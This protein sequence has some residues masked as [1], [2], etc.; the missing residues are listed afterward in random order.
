MKTNK[1]KTETMMFPSLLMALIPTIA[2][3]VHVIAIVTSK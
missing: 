1:Q 3:A 2:L